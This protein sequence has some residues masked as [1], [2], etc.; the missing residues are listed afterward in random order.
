[1]VAIVGLL[2]RSLGLIFI[3]SFYFSLHGQ[4][5][6]NPSFEG[7]PGPSRMPPDWEACGQGSTP[8]TQ[9]GSWN[10]FTAPASGK[11]YLSMIC[12]GKGVPFPEKWE[13]CQQKLD[14]PLEKNKCYYY[15]L[16][17]AR[18]ATFAS[19]GLWFIGEVNL[20][21]WGG[22]E[23]CNPQTLLWESGPVGHTQWETYEIILSPEKSHNYFFLEAYY[24]GTHVY[25]GNV[26]IDNFLFHPDIKPCYTFSRK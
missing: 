1:M 16:D 19:A 18:S 2:R 12:R 17:L 3:L 20:R 7:P 14:Q 10:V 25:S 15:T 4:F 8:D 5:L 26:L 23:A 21:L 11:S 6:R 13:W 22:K 24:Q 9:P